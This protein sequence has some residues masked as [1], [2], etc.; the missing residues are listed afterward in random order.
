[1]DILSPINM[2]SEV[3]P[4]RAAG[5]TELYCGL[6][7]RET[8]GEYTSVFPLNSRHVAEANVSSFEELAAITAAAHR[9]GMKLFLTYNA[10]YTER[11]FETVKR[12]LPRALDSG[13]DGLIVADIALMIHLKKEFPDAAFIASTLGG[14]F[15]SRAARLYRDLGAARVTLPRHLTVGEIKDVAAACPDVEFEVFIMSERCYFPNALCRF[16]HATYRV[17]GGPLSTLSAAAGR[18][19]GRRAALLTGTYNNR[20][21]NSLQDRFFARNGMMCLREYEA[22]LVDAA[23]GATLRKGLPFRFVDC[24]N[25]FREACGLCAIYDIARAENVRSLKIVGRQSLTSKK[26]ADT[27]MTRRALELLK[28]NPSREE[29]VRAAKKIRRKYYPRYCGGGYCYYSEPDRA[30]AS[31]PPGE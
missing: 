11:Q 2:L 14:A 10:F 30:E 15:N 27:D 5:A 21:V 7:R 20:I 1:M 23:S 28:S 31:R 13:V 9:L 17:R 26:L 4:L 19:L 16:E 22:E 8:L 6:M 18:L 24:W 29:F 25:S 12:E 3:E